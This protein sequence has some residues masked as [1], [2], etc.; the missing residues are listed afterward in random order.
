MVKLLHIKNNKGFTLVEMIIVL[1]G[2]NLI[3]IKYFI[4]LRRIRFK[5][6]HSIKVVFLKIMSLRH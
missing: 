2:L 4:K 1:F 3:Q 5:P 6:S